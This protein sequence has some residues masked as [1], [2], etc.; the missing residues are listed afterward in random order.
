M[1]N[2]EHVQELKWDHSLTDAQALRKSRE[3]AGQFAAQ[4]SRHIT[5]DGHGG[6]H[7]LYSALDFLAK[8]GQAAVI[9][10][11][12]GEHQDGDTAAQIA[13]R[14]SRQDKY[15]FQ[16]KTDGVVERQVENH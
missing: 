6:R 9:I 10:Q 2:Q 12:P 14:K 4:Q 16:Q 7:R 3:H 8:Y 13:N 15:N 1:D 11:D 5:P